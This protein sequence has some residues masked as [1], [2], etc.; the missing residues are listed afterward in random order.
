MRRR[1]FAFC[2]RNAVK[3]SVAGALPTLDGADYFAFCPRSAVRGSVVGALPTSGG[4]DYFCVLPEE[5]RE[6]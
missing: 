3:G 4:A 1:L 5:R 2:P 6:G